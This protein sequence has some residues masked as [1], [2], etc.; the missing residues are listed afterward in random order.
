MKLAKYLEDKAIARGDFARK[1]K[2]TQSYVTYLC[3]GKAW[4]SKKVMARIE[5]ATN[6]EVR[7]NDFLQ[8]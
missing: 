6:G 5:R 4:P 1:I 3:A 8:N 2:V 7:A